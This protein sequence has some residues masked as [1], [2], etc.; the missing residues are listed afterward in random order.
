MTLAGAKG[1]RVAGRPVGQAPEGIGRW[2]K[3]RQSVEMMRNKSSEIPRKSSEIPRRSGEWD[4]AEGGSGSGQSR[5][6]NTSS[7]NSGDA[8][9]RNSSMDSDGMTRNS[10]EARG[11][12][13]SLDEQLGN[14]CSPWHPCDNNHVRKSGRSKRLSEGRLARAGQGAGG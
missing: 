7:R 8:P 1:A 4:V 2:E 12:S 9:R 3:G 14:P 13:L 10:M 5:D 11:S 6:W